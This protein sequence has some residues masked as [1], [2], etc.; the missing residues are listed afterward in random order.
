MKKQDMSK[1]EKMLMG[2]KEENKMSQKGMDVKMEMLKELMDAAKDGMKGKLLGEM[3]G[4]K[5]IT[6]ASPSQEGLEEGLDKAKELLGSEESEESPEHEEM[7]SPEMEKGE[8]E[9]KS[10]LP[11]EMPMMEEEEEEYSPFMKRKKK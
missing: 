5:K 10:E 6:V 11:M 8:E 7:E 1:L 2:Q 3:E 9:E 4:M